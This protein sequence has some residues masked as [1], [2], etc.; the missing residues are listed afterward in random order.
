[1]QD[2]LVKGR[3]LHIVAC[4]QR[5]DRTNPTAGVQIY[6]DGQFRMGPPSPGTLYSNPKFLIMPA[7]GTAPL[8]LGTRDLGSFLR[9]GLDEVAIYPYVLSANK[10]EEHYKIAMGD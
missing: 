3:W 1:V 5:G 4:Y 9:G 8:R 7:H 2:K 10:V 6:K